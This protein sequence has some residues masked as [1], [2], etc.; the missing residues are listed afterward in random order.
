MSYLPLKFSE[1]ELGSLR[2]REL[3]CIASEFLVSLQLTPDVFLLEFIISIGLL[4]CCDD[5]RRYDDDLQNCLS[6]IMRTVQVTK[7]IEILK[8]LYDFL[9]NCG[10]QLMRLSFGANISSLFT[11]LVLRSDRNLFCWL[12]RSHCIRFKPD[13]LWKE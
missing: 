12:Y 6:I 3:K 10:N 7:Q 11:S 13:C 8:F 4:F 5:G 9:K 1:F 2:E